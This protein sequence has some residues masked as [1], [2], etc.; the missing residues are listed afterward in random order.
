MIG[1]FTL[2]KRGLHAASRP[3]VLENLRQIFKVF[4]E[5]FEVKMVFGSR[6]VSIRFT[7]KD[8]PK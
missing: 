6:E 5:A 2:F 8:N 7:V 4:V 3:E 1:Y